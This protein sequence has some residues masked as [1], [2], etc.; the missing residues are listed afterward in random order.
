[1]MSQHSPTLRLHA[2]LTWQIQTRTPDTATWS[3]IDAANSHL[4]HLQLVLDD[5][6]SDVQTD[7]NPEHKPE[8][9]RLETKLDYLIDL[10]GHLARQQM[11]LPEPVAVSLSS[12]TLCWHWGATPPTE[13]SLVKVELFL[14]PVITQAL[15]LFVTITGV[16]AEDTGGYQ[17]QAEMI[18][19]NAAFYQQ[20]DRIIFRHHRRE[21]AHL[22]HG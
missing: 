3:Q 13:R 10:I 6:L 7:D 9:Q 16:I 4:L 15:Q 12:Y 21:I 14:P 1:M 19:H 18:S 22:R 11:A 17:I 2:P 20:L 8:L 5:K